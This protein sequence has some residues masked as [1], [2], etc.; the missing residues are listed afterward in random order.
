MLIKL[1]SVIP[2]I[3][4]I[5]DIICSFAIIPSMKHTV[6]AHDE[7]PINGYKIKDSSLPIEAIIEFSIDTKPFQKSQ[8]NDNKNHKRIEDKKTIVP[9]LLINS[10]TLSDASLI[11][12]LI[13]GILYK[14]NS[15][16]K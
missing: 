15:I 8:E 6:A 1:V 10:K 4:L 9:A 11:I 16:R 7:V 12:F 14:G 3:K 13:E 5:L 2:E